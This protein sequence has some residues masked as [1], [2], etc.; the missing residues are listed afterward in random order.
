MTALSR[1]ARLLMAGAFVSD[2]IEA[3]RHPGP[4]AELVRQSGL[5]VQD[6]EKVVRLNA[7]ADVLGGL[8]LATARVPRLASL[9]LASS[10]AP[11]TYA[12][13]AFWREKDKGVRTQQQAH[14]LKN[15]GLLGGLLLSAADTGGRESLPHAAGRLTR[16]AASDVR[17]HVPVD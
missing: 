5:P 2:G 12:A 9:A 15:L 10:L 7:A 1:V 4:R 11:T 6:P 17:A 14:F 8:A 3:L 16:R 13:H